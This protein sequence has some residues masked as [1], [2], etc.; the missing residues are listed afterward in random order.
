MAKR[1]LSARRNF[2]KTFPYE[3][4]SWR[5]M[6]ERCK[7]KKY[8][9]FDLYGGRGIKVCERW[10]TFQNFIAD[11][12]PKPT[13]KHSIDRID[14]D[15][16]YEPSNCRWA[17]QQEQVRNSSVIREIA[18]DG[19]TK[20]LSDWNGHNGLPANVI[21]K[22]LL[23]GWS[24]DSAMTVPKN[25]LAPAV[26]M[27]LNGTTDSMAGWSRRLGIGKTTLCA[28]LKRGWSIEKTLTAP[29]R[30][31]IDNERQV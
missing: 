22:R 3:Y 31:F 27:T 17:T 21:C 24:T 25:D 28:R 20:I 30:T 5:A 23:R 8:R 10:A 11:M 9:R 4:N 26:L 1:I 6:H 12:G 16:N 7:N 13:P 19:E 15:G 2:K 14:G 18:F 29:V